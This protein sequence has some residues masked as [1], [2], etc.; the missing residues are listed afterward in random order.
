VTSTVLVLVDDV[1]VEQAPGGGAQLPRTGTTSWPLV[2][3]GIVLLGAGL[4]ISAVDVLRT[5]RARS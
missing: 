5:R 3:L 4:S 2:V 1:V